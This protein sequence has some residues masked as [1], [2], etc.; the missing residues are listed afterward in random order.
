MGGSGAGLTRLLVIGPRALGANLVKV[1]PSAEVAVVDQPLEGVWQS[2]LRS[3]DGVLISLALGQRALQVARAVRQ[4]APTTRV[5][6]TC[7]ANQ[8]PS[9]RAAL[10]CGAD[11]YIV[12]PLCAEDLSRALGAARS[13]V[14]SAT[15]G[16]IP[17][18]ANPPPASV[19]AGASAGPSAEELLGFSEILRDLGAGPQAV[20]DRLARLVRE[21]LGAVGVRL[22]IDELEGVAGDVSVSVLEEPVLRDGEVVGRIALGRRADGA[23]GAASISRL[24]RYAVLAG[25]AVEGARKHAHWQRLAWTD[26]V[27]G[28]R[29]RRFL[30]QRLD[31][32]LAQATDR[33]ERLTV[34]LFDIDEFKSYNDRYGHETGDALISEIGAV[35]RGCVRETDVVARFGGDEF[36]VIFWD[37]EPPRTPG[38]QHP[39]DPLA[40]AERFSQRILEHSFQC[41]GTAGPGPVT[42]SGGLAC[43][44]WDGSTRETLLK[45]A[46][47]ALLAA[48]RTGKSRIQVAGGEGEPPAE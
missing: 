6:M 33:R 8:E 20:V 21:A 25:A 37:A 3:Y 15:I 26:D 16:A 38:S 44:P 12:E 24:G 43:Y 23:Y 9:A 19:A 39:N 1:L 41:L 42:I 2:G 4:V 40:L 45:A 34:L 48:K 35:L 7:H 30:E 22:V 10:D 31:E 36:A 32:L 11:D 14:A 46:D 28:L 29:N 13:P 18:A 17:P 5:L 47:Q 27:S